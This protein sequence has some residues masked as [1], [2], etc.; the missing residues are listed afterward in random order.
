MKQAMNNNNIFSVPVTN[1]H[2]LPTQFPTHPD[3]DFL[4]GS[5]SHSGFYMDKPRIPKSLS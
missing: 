2:Y 4:L 5:V 1:R 3:F